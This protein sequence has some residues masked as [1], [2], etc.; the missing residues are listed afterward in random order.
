MEME[1][2]T[3]GTLKFKDMTG[4]SEADM[5][6]TGLNALM[7]SKEGTIPGSREFGLPQK[8][9][10]CPQSE[11]AMN[12]LGIELSG[13]AKEYFPEIYIKAVTGQT[14]VDGDFKATIIVERR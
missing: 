6:G 4:A 1:A 9:L 7:L 14:S 8:F 3:T 2:N 5:V 12:I 11:M 10:S 13:K